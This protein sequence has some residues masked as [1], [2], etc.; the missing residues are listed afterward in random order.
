MYKGSNVLFTAVSSHAFYS[1]GDVDEFKAGVNIFPQ[2]K[3]LGPISLTYN[4]PIEK[5]KI[6]NIETLYRKINRHCLILIDIT[7]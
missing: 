2:K 1:K 6:Q 3:S 5:N 4:F 7:K